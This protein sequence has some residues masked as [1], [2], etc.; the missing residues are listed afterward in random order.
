[1]ADLIEDPWQVLLCAPD[2]AGCSVEFSDPDFAVA[3]RDTLYYV[4]AIQ[5]PTTAI[6][7]AQLRCEFDE[8]GQ[9]RSV[10]PCYADAK[11]EYEDD[12]LAEGEER[13]WSSP[14]YLEFA[15]DDE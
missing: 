8:A 3:R 6:N 7:G 15:R 2:A 9:C 12:C 4:R 14:I 1:V 5:E 11:T 13:A 10:L